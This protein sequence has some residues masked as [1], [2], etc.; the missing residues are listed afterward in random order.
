MFKKYFIGE[1]VENLVGEEVKFILDIVWLC[2]WEGEVATPAYP[3]FN[4]TRPPLFTAVDALFVLFLPFSASSSKG[5]LSIMM[6][7]LPAPPV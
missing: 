7:P 5:L 2:L 6:F 4:T 3:G 1:T